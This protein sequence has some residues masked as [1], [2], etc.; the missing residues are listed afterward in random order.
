MFFNDY[1]DTKVIYH[2]TPLSKLKEVL[3]KGIKLNEY[4]NPDYCEFN[5]YF[6]RFKNDTIP[7]WVL[8]EKAIYGSINFKSDHKWHSHS[9]ILALTIN[10]ERCWIGN[11]NLANILYEP[12]VLKDLNMFKSAEILIKARGDEF[13]LNY[14]NN[15]LSFRQNLSTRL[16][17]T[18]GYDAEVLIMQDI[19]PR[20]IN[21][22]KL[23]S[24]HKIMDVK[25]WNTEFESL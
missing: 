15:S 22:I 9:A 1:T 12:Y 16:D 21:V 8:R 23:V 17:F 2:I 10:E 18:E 13:P 5:R 24:D 20:D 4:M 25:E 19:S 14:W 11:E 7:E 3:E 6:D